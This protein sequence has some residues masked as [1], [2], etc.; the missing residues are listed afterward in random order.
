MEITKI[1]P[2]FVGVGLIYADD[3]AH[4][5]IAECE[6]SG[7]YYHDYDYDKIKLCD[8]CKIVMKMNK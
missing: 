4:N 6:R 8:S 7:Q 3:G 5:D 2:M 1:K